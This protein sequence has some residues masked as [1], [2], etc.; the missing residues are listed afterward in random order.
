MQNLIVNADDFG[1]TLS[2]NDAIDYAFKEGIINRTTIMVT[3][4][5]VQDA[6]NK[7]IWGGVF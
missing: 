5:C 3:H 7:S 1:R 4:P 2:I 6:V